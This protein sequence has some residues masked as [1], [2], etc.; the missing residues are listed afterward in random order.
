MDNKL[1]YSA[2]CGIAADLPFYMHPNYL[3]VVCDGAWEVAIV[4]NQAR[5]IAAMPYFVKKKLGF[6]YIT[7]P[8]LCKAMGPYLLP[9]YR[10]T[11]YEHK[12]FE[13]L[14]NQLPKVDYFT[15]DFHYNYQNWLP[16]YW[17][18]FKQTTRYTYLI[19]DLKNLEE[20]WKGI[21]RSYRN[22][23]IPKAKESLKIRTDLSLTE[24]YTVHKK[25]FDRQNIK[26]PFTFDYL[27]NIDY[28]LSQ[29]NRKKIFYAI[30]NENNIHSVFYLAWDNM[31]AY[32]LLMGDDPH[33]RQQGGS[34]LL[35]W[36]AIRF[37]SEE[38]Q[39]NTFD[40][41]GSMIKPI[42]IVR[43][44]FGAI[45]QPYLS[46]SKANHPILKMLK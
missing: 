43:R 40:F 16:F 42:E 25:T 14:I 46:I 19:N 10:K 28:T 5:V 35:T 24:F 21:Y 41:L 3:D 4:E 22:N 37:A 39:L 17:K 34:I 36:E 7:M 23:I 11:D 31:S 15:Q 12:I 26:V 27:Q 45:Q 6:R 9:I 29:M 13:A 18:G 30:D 2:L 1:K 33:F 20:V 44:N 32:C 8:K 38:L